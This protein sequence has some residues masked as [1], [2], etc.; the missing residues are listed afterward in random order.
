MK[1][2]LSLNGTPPT[3]AD[4]VLLD[5]PRFVASAETGPDGVFDLPDLD[6]PGTLLVRIRRPAIVVAS[7]P[8]SAT[9]IDL[10]PTL[11][12]VSGRVVG[13]AKAKPPLS[14]YADPTAIDGFSPLL[15]AYVL[16]RSATVRL[17]HFAELPVPG[18]R[19]ELT[20]AAGTYRLTG[21]RLD[22]DQGRTT[23]D[24]P[25][26]VTVDA[27]TTGTGDRLPGDP[28]SGFTITVTTDVELTLALREVATD[29]L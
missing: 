12:R 8:S 29:E 22:Y 27:I 10:S 21:N 4:V 3:E 9:E 2:T 16:Q 15:E 23:D 25:P 1:R 14:V 11:C 17:S 26:S 19:F 18:D 5:G 6:L 13:T 24:L 7:A 28:W 20:V